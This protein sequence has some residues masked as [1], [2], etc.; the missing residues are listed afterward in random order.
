[1]SCG[2]APCGGRRGRS[3]RSSRR[4]W[5]KGTCC[6][7]DL[8]ELT[9]RAPRFVVA[10][11][12]DRD[13]RVRRAGAAQR[14]RRRGA[15]ARRPRRR[16]HEGLGEQLVARAARAAPGSTASTRCA[17]SRMA[18]ASSCASASPSFRTTGCAR[19]SS[20]TARAARCSARCGQHAVDAAAP[21]DGRAR[22]MTTAMSLASHRRR[23]RRHRAARLPC[24]RPALRDQG[25]RPSRPVAG[26]LRRTWPPPPASSP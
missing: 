19:R 10:G 2:R 4:T 1:M 24:R 16:P 11:L 25:Q 13:R 20:P 15:L 26:R 8:D 7:A 23:R 17:R 14:P 9:V 12:G 21:V 5:K 3:T 22:G 6:R 18:R